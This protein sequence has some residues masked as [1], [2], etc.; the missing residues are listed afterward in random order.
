M[1]VFT[2]GQGLAG[3]AVFKTIEDE[4]G[5]I[6][7]ITS[8]G[9]SAVRGDS[10][11]TPSFNSSLVSHKK[12]SLLKDIHIT[13]TGDIYATTVGPNSGYFK[14]EGDDVNFIQFEVEIPSSCKEQLFVMTING[15]GHCSG[16]FQTT[17]GLACHDTI[18]E[19]TSN[20][21]EIK[22]YHNSKFTAGNNHYKTGSYFGKDVISIRNELLVFE[23][24]REIQHLK[25]DSDILYHISYDQKLYVSLRGNGILS[26]DEELINVDT[27]L[28]EGSISFFRFIDCNV[29]EC[30]DL[31]SGYYLIAT[32]DY[33]QTGIGEYFSSSIVASPVLVSNDSA[34]VYSNGVFYI[35]YR[36]EG[37][38]LENKYE[39]LNASDYSMQFSK[40][41]WRNGFAY[42]NHGFVDMKNLDSLFYTENFDPKNRIKY[43]S[44]ASDGSQWL[45]TDHS[46]YTEYHG[47]LLK[48]L[49]LKGH[50]RIQSIIDHYGQI[51]LGTDQGLFALNQKSLKLDT[52]KGSKR[53]VSLI[54]S[55]SH[56]ALSFFDD[57]SLVHYSP[58]GLCSID[59]WFL[60]EEEIVYDMDPAP[61]GFLW[62][63]TNLGVYRF[64]VLICSNSVNL[65]EIDFFNA[66]GLRELHV[67]G[68]SKV[69]GVKNNSLVE[70]EQPNC[71][72]EIVK[73]RYLDDQR[74]KLTRTNHYNRTTE[75]GNI[76]NSIAFDICFDIDQSKFD[77]MEEVYYRILGFDSVWQVYHG[78]KINIS[79]LPDGRFM[80]CFVGLDK[81]EKWQLLERYTFSKS[82]FHSSMEI[83]LIVMFI[84]VLIL[85]VFGVVYVKLDGNTPLFLGTSNKHIESYHSGASQMSPHFLF[86]SLNAVKSLVLDSNSKAITY[87]NAVSNQLRETM[88]I[89]KEVFVPLGAEL[90]RLEAY[91]EIEQIRQPD[92][93]S[94]HLIRDDSLDLDRFLVPPM[95]LQPIVE[96]CI[97]HAFEGMTNGAFIKVIIKPELDQL[98]IDV[99]DNGRGMKLMDKSDDQ[100]VSVGLNN[101]TERLRALS[102][103]QKQKFELSIFSNRE[104][105]TTVRLSI[106]QNI[107]V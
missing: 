37:V 86:N 40:V 36:V 98:N 106:P 30:S 63:S 31:I 5:K 15:S 107:N 78:T 104:N 18:I 21:C 33:S 44:W 58:T 84:G 46:L 74:I 73:R 19:F 52:L 102:N 70:L 76:S 54:N 87:I 88:A 80:L 10:I 22:V 20:E 77:R 11:Y 64:K 39:I 47:L 60:A 2:D 3:K 1:H 24:G 92:L 103:I 94:Y 49:D 56:G 25:F 43:R 29:I 26:I 89:T 34:T 71:R 68:E 6:W 48:K 35:Y 72:N 53:V 97:V 12:Y 95:M 23:S 79:D 41:H 50:G 61:D 93:F 59:C 4:T 75:L 100:H 67:T 69:F 14:I 28:D 27:L 9:I 51:L 32:K 101:I 17:R 8:G 55:D 38:W 13:K 91:I 81:F 65:N 45:A 96:N 7:F 62:L 66:P 57:H 16:I 85:S 82:A 83:P 90:K 105:G 42:F 99:L